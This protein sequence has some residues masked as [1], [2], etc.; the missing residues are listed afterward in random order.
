MTRSRSPGQAA[1]NM[2]AAAAENVPNLS[3]RNPQLR[4]ISR[5]FPNE[6]RNCEK[7]F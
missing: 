7:R 2:F 6:I 5:A 3:E 4:K 1:E